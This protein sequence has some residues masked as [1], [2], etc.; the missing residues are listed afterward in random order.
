ML[1][2]TRLFQSDAARWRGISGYVS[3]AEILAKSYASKDY[4]PLRMLEAHRKNCADNRN[5]IKELAYLY[6]SAFCFSAFNYYVLPNSFLTL[7]YTNLTRVASEGI[8]ELVFLIFLLPLF[9][10]WFDASDKYGRGSYLNHDR[11]YAELKED[12]R[13]EREKRGH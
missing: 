7:G 13:K 5:E 2:Y 4:E 6:F 8:A 1:S 3:E 10:I 12:K 9:L 11:M